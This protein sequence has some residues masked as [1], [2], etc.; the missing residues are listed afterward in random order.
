[1]IKIR[2]DR[3]EGAGILTNLAIE[4]LLEVCKWLILT[5]QRTSLLL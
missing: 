4:K 5:K 2:G 3:G 1:M